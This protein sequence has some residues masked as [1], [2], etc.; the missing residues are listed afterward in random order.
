MVKLDGNSIL[1]NSNES[2][3]LENY[4]RD[5]TDGTLYCTC[6]VQRKPSSSFSDN[7]AAGVLEPASA[8]DH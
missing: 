7:A 1:P 5:I 8:S 3:I 2:A 4:P 6:K